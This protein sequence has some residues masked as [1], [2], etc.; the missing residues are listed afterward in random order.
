MNKTRQDPLGSPAEVMFKLINDTSLYW[1]KTEYNYS[2][3]WDIYKIHIK[4]G[5]LN[6][7]WLHTTFHIKAAVSP[8][9]MVIFLYR[10][11]LFKRSL[12]KVQ[13]INSLRRG[14]ICLSRKVS[15]SFRWHLV[16]NIWTINYWTNFLYQHNITVFTW[17]CNLILQ[18]Y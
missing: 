8:L 5:Q 6:I 1:T 3:M 18:F 12:H 7:S 9:C 14:Q 17:I 11:F 13:Q 16:S 15:H 2:I 10:P 4:L